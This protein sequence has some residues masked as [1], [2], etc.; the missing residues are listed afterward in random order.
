MSAYKF[1]IGEIVTLRRAIGSERARGAYGGH[2]TASRYGWR[3]RIP[4]QKRERSV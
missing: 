1:K 4:H 2:Q 3:A